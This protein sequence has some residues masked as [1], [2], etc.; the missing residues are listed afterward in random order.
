MEYLG[1]SLGFGLV[2]SPQLLVDVEIA[3]LGVSC[4]YQCKHPSVYAV[5]L[6]VLLISSVKELH[7]VLIV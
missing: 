2:F 3:L 4:H 7:K 1:V 6:L 5:K